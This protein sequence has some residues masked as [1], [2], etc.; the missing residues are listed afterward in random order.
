MESSTGYGYPGSLISSSVLF[1]FLFNPFY[2]LVRISA[3]I[4][5]GEK[6]KK[7]IK[8]YGEYL[9]GWRA[10]SF[11]SMISSVVGLPSIA[12]RMACRVAL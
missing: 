2:A 1:Y 3:G 8:N 7:L 4:K 5:K 11:T 10:L 12:L 6:E 9:K